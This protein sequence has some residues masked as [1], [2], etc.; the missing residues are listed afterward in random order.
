VSNHP[1]RENDIARAVHLLRQHGVAVGFPM[2]TAEGETI[3]PLDRNLTLT[4]DQLLQLLERD[5]LT[6]EGVRKVVEAIGLSR[7]RA[8]SS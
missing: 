6:A 1:V 5:E 2:Q 7:G 3:F 8:A 4:A